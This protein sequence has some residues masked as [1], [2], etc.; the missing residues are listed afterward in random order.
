MLDALPQPFSIRKQSGLSTRH[1]AG[2]KLER[3]REH[4]QQ[5]VAD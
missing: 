3:D 5:G 2:P 1:I 4:Q